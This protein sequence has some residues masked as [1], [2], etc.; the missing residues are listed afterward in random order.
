MYD[1]KCLLM[2]AEKKGGKNEKLLKLHKAGKMRKNDFSRVWTKQKVFHKQKGPKS[3][4]IWLYT[5][6]ST[7][8]TKTNHNFCDLHNMGGERAFC[9]K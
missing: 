5:E 1:G 6:L 3:G 7:I 2:T 4:E 9:E 8:S